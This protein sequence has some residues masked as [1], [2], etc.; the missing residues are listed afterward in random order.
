MKPLPLLIHCFCIAAGYAG[1]GIVCIL[2][3]DNA[4]KGQAWPA[5]VNVVSCMFFGGI[6][7]NSLSILARIVR[8]A[9]EQKPIP[10]A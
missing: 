9:S 10:P 3:I 6:A 5:V 7:H 2:C 1:A 4:Q 8:H